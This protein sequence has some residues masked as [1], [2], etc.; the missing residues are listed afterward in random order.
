MNKIPLYYNE[1][2]DSYG[3]LISPDFGAGWGSW[4]DIEAA[5]D[6]RVIQLWL[7]N[8]ENEEWMKNVTSYSDNK[9]K[10]EVEELFESWG[11][12]YI[13]LRGLS[14]AHLVWVPLGKKWRIKEYDGAESIVFDNEEEWNIFYE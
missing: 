9:I 2:H 5:Y 14:G 12:N 8:F 3:V 7:E 4:N 1:A 6:A 11:Y 10:N 13:Y